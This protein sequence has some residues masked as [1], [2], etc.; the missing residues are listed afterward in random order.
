MKVKTIFINGQIYTMNPK[1]PMVQSILMNNERIIDMGSNEEILLLWG[2]N[3]AKIIDLEGRTVL[4]GLIDSHLH[5]S[6]VGINSQEL[7]LTHVRSADELLDSIKNWA[8]K[9]KPGEWILGRGW[10]ENTF[11]DKRIP[12]IEELDYVSLNIPLYLPRICG[13]ASLVN[14]TAFKISGYHPHMTIPYGGTVVLNS[15]TK[16]PNGLLLE[17]ASTI[18]SK[19]IPKKSY[20]QL[21][22]ALK[23]GLQKAISFGLTSI[24]TNDPNYLGGA[25]QTYK[26]FDELINHDGIGP[27]SNLLIDYD[28]LEEMKNIGLS[29][30]FGNNKVM[31]GAIKLFA[32]GA[33]GGRTAHL[34]E[35][36]I[37]DPDNVGNAMYDNEVLFQL[38]RNIRLQ[39]MPVAIHT[40]GDQALVDV[41]NILDQFKTTKYRDRL[42]HVSLLNEQLIQRLSNSHRI[43]DVQPKF[44]SSD[45]PWIE[46]RIGKQRAKFAYPFKSLLDS[47]VICAGS[48]D[49]PIEPLNPLLGI[50][51]ALTRRKSGESHD[52]YNVKEKLTIYE[53]IKLFTVGGAYATN[54]ELVKGTLERGKLGDMTVLSHDPFRMENPDQL[55]T[56]EIEMTVIGGEIKYQK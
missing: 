4:P 44:V 20:E 2:R 36:Y 7:D 15:T 55:L 27:R 42:I 3:G 12:T 14:S 46:D 56:T 28:Y 16:K 31:I 41:L 18:V 23:C 29:T 48:S 37:D 38:I 47:G 52:G 51:A 24:H 26:L 32:D 34:S 5:I 45:Y 11:L 9:M 40:I 25:Q 35:P 8:T 1:E 19:H 10:D 49:A 13:H 17:T 33:L 21:K 53:A 54:E 39:E 30:G 22:I 43:V 50:H 6:S